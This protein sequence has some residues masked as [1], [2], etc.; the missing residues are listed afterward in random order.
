MGLYGRCVEKWACYAHCYLMIHLK[1][2]HCSFFRFIFMTYYVLKCSKMVD[3]YGFMVYKFWIFLIF[4]TKQKLYKINILRFLSS[5]GTISIVLSTD[6]QTYRRTSLDQLRILP[7]PRVYIH[8]GVLGEY[9]N[10]LQT[11]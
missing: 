4:N 6:R 5:Y 11:E 2:H 10:M 3:F 1:F 8:V 7:G 9:F